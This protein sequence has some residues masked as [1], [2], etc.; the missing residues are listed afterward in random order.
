[1]KRIAILLA[2][3]V[4]ACGPAEPVNSPDPLDGNDVDVPADSA[5]ANGLI[6]FLNDDSATFEVLDAI[7]DS[8]AA[9]GLVENRPYATIDDVDAVPYVGPV[10]IAELTAYLDDAGYLAYQGGAWEGVS[11]TGPPGLR[12]QALALPGG[13]SIS[14]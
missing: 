4:A 7:I 10:A 14:R 5:E 13:P 9:E 12:R 1:M 6:E 8:R 2:L 11:F 3:S